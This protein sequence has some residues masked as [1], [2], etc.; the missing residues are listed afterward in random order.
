MTTTAPYGSWASPITAATV[1]SGGVRLGQVAWSGEDLCWLEG[2]PDEGG[3]NV[4]V[5]RS[6][7]GTVADDIPAGF[8][9]RTTVHEYGGGSFWTAGSTVFFTNFDD[10]RLYRVDPGGEPVPITPEPPARWGLRYADGVV[11]PDG[12][13]VVCVR[14]RH[15]IGREAVNEIVA[16]PAGGP[17]GGP[18]AAT[19][20]V[21]SEPWIL[22]TG[23]TFYAFP[24]LNA[25]GT[26]LAWTSWGHP[27]MPWDGTELWVADLTQDGRLGARRRV[28]GGVE[29]S[30]F[31]PSFGPPSGPSSGPG[32][33]LFFV[34]DRSGWWNLYVERDGVVQAVAPVDAELGVPQWVFGLSTYVVL[35]DGTI[36]CLLGGQGGTRLRRIVDGGYQDLGLPYRSFPPASLVGSGNRVAFVG[37]SPVQ[38]AAV[39]VVDLATGRDEVVRRSLA[40]DIEP[41]LVSVP[42]PITFP[43]VLDGEPVE[44]HALFYRPF[45]PAFQAP[46][47]ERSPLIVYSHG[48]PTSATSSALNPEIQFWTSRGIGV[49]DVNYGG[50]TGYG[51]PYR[52]RL[53]GRWGVVDVDDCVA[54]ATYL[55]ER[56]DADPARLAIRGGSA[57]GYTT[58]CALTFRQVFAAGASYYGVADAAALARDTHKFESRYL[59]SLIGPYPAEEELYRQRSPIHFTDR[60]STPMLV[61]QGLED[62]VVPPS[63]A[64]AM[65]AALQAKG[66]PHAYLPFEGEQHGFRRAENIRRA[67]EAE[68]SFYAQIFGFEPAGEVERLKIENLG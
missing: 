12:R 16:I 25:E 36:L 7:D 51:R 62:M 63:Q 5:R 18:A 1:A 22:V 58:L 57:G 64:E 2:R 39:V 55:V 60:L 32:G 67:L 31:Q 65:V 23:D 30:I 61:L 27:R 33:D 19:A 45:N 21:G 43:S 37:A 48:G 24:R 59:D 54:A 15:M 68:L 56:G 11:T 53:K 52:E 3:R 50:S 34:S 46:E 9:A 10:Q 41:S 17:A 29:E 28:V 6:A 13:W 38:A 20:D 40:V 4:I 44:A 26:R 47:G 35:E 14:E 42:E 8:N 49:V 66:I